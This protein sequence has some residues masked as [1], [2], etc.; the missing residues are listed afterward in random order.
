[1]MVVMTMMMMMMM[2]MVIITAAQLS[3]DKQSQFISTLGDVVT[4]M[5]IV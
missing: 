5:N 3:H 1:M 2:M 4:A